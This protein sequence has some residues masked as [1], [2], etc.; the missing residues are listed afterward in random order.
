MR[1]RRHNPLATRILRWCA[2][3]CLLAGAIVLVL[4]VYLWAD[5]HVYQ[6]LQ[7]RR[8][9]EPALA[10]PLRERCQ[11]SDVGTGS[12]IGRLEIPQIS[13]SVVVLEGDDART[14]RLGAGRV[15]GTARPGEGS[16]MAIA[17]HRDT[18]FRALRNIRQGDVIRFTSKS[19]AFVYQVDSS[20]IVTPSHVEVLDATAQPTLTLI[21]C[22]PFFYFGSA[23]ERLVVRARLI[24]S[25]PRS[26]ANGCSREIQENQSMDPLR[27]FEIA[28][29]VG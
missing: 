5:A 12:P 19:E 2:Y 17:A 23:P 24:S 8:L 7:S 13:L 6:A 28:G 10:E 4:C 11:P 21:T 1:I 3:S 16:N 18:F 25:E 22:Y 15:P 20:E 29:R 27:N 9:N 14:L 26:G